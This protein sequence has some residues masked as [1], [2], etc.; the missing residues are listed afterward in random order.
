MTVQNIHRADYHNQHFRVL[1]YL[2]MQQTKRVGEW[3]QEGA[4]NYTESKKLTNSL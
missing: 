4:V 2:Q 3:R 1:T